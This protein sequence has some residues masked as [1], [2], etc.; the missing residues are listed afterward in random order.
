MARLSK[1]VSIGNT[2]KAI[3]RCRESGVMLNASLIF[4]MDE[5]DR[6]LFDRTLGFLMEHKV[7][8]VSAYVLTPYP[9]TAVYRRMLAQNRLIHR[10]WAYYDHITPVFRPA[11]MSPA[12]LA[13]RYMR[14]RKDLF[15][16]KGICRRLLPQ[17]SIA[18][19]AYVGL[20]MA[21]RQNS[22]LL[23]EHY[24]RYFRWMETAIPPGDRGE[25]GV[26]Q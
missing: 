22:I 20:N 21:H 6:T 11:L 5:H 23:E 25:P 4:G 12:E 2:V 3:R 9:G 19:L 10:N 7:P 15:G 26:S 1:S 16:L 13:E 17:V 14:F 24:R 18:P 8:S